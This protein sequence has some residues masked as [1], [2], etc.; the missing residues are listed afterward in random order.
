[1]QFF[2]EA[3][4]FIVGGFVFILTFITQFVISYILS[5]RKITAQNTIN[6]SIEK[7][8][9]EYA[10]AYQ[11]IIKNQSTPVYLGCAYCQTPQYVEL[12]FIKDNVFQCYTC[13][14]KNKV[15]IDIRPVRITTPLEGDLHIQEI[16]MPGDEKEEKQ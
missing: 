15:Y 9:I 6:E 16:K 1:M 3:N 13:N 11:E 10:E 12:S 4:V 5:E 8:A 2:L 14:Q 7:I